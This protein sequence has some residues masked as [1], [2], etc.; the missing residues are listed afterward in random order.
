MCGRFTR[1]HIWK[2]V[3]DYLSLFS[4]T[5]SNL[6]PR[7]NIAPTTDCE[8]VR[9]GDGGREMFT[10]RWGL[11]PHWA[12]DIKFGAKTFNARSETV[13][14]KPSFRDAFKKRRCVI[15]AS[16]Y[17]EWRT[18]SG[19]KQPYHFTI[20]DQPVMVFAGLWE[21]NKRVAEDPIVSFTILTTDANKTVSDYHHRMPVLLDQ[22]G[23]AAWMDEDA[24]VDDME[25]LMLPFAGD[26]EVTA[27]NPKVGRVKEQ[28]A[29]L[30]GSG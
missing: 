24:G 17:Y 26:I 23:I 25:Q 8:V 6:Q 15:P 13:A 29:D 21:E 20:P 10:A 30:I 11:L 12:K 19:K 7:Y 27:A 2:E 28:G 14:E 16:G 3:H 4:T 18:E 9:E 5:A 22:E 1:Y